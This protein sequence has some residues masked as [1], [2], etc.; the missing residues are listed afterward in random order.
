M[1][2]NKREIGDRKEREAAIYLEEQGYT[3]LEKNFYGRYGE[4]DLIA[5]SPDGIM[6]FV[7]VKYRADTCFGYPEEAI[8]RR[9]QKNIERTAQEYLY[10]RN[11]PPDTPCRYDAISITGKELHHLEQAFGGW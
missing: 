1:L 9:K 7:E 6:V 3:I 4:I 11:F 8:G 5:L 2:K 10:N